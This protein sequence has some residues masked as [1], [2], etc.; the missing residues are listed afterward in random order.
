MPD[1]LASAR[2]RVVPVVLVLLCGL[3]LLLG[4]ANKDRC[5]GPEFDE[6]GRSTPGYAERTFADACYSDIQFLWLGRHIDRHTFPYVHGELVD[7]QLVGGALE[8]PVLTGLLMWTAGH[9]ASTDAGFLLASA[10][11]L[12]PFGLLAAW[13]LGRL[14]GWRALLWAVGPPLVLYAF[15]NWDLPAVAATVAA[16]AVV[17]LGRGTLRTRGT[18]AAVLLGLGFALKV[19]PAMFVLPLAAYVLTGGPDGRHGWDPRGALRVVGAA[20]GTAAVVNLPFALAGFPGWWASFRF[21]A[22]RKV[23]VTT[24]SIWYWGFRPISE[25]D[26]EGFQRLVGVLSPALVLAA[27]GVALAV[28]W[29]RYRREGS[30]PLLGVSAAMLCGFLLLHKVHSPQYTLWLLPMFVLLR[31]RWG[32]VLGY[33]LADLALGIGIFHWYGLLASGGA[34]IYEG[35]TAQAVMIGVWGRAA[36]LAGL[37]VAFLSARP[38]VPVSSLRDVHAVPDGLDPR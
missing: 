34:A 4:F 9:F 26:N 35:F 36:L 7:G 14:S 32:W 24:N 12:A 8:Y 6:R 18:W 16:F 2:T 13:L 33:L 25:G 15:H 31:V 22:E 23:D 19:Y 27:F 28:G 29:H 1:T 17:F 21:Q 11:L 3:T 10:L 30:F 20:V 38:A 5:T 37:F